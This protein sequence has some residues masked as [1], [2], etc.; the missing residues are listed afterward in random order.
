[1]CHQ[2][3][4]MTCLPR[5]LT[6]PSQRAVPL[7]DDSRTEVSLWRNILLRAYTLDK[8]GWIRLQVHSPAFQV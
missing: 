8:S 7:C 4:I 1:M 5:E 3:M 6:P 2:G